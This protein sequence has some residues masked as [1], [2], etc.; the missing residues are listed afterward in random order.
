MSALS[1]SLSGKTVVIVGGASGI[2]FAVAQAARAEGAMVRIASSQA[3][4]VEAAVSR[5]GPGASGLVVD[6]TDEASVE[7]LFTALG[8]ID[9]L[10]YTAGDWAGGAGAPTRDL[11]LAAAEAGLRVRFWG[12]LRVVK[13]GCRTLSTHGSIT[14][15]DGMFAHR[16]RKGAP[17]M[18]A[19]L[20]ALEHLTPAL[21]VDLAP[22]R[23]N[24]VCPGLVMTE[25]TLEMP[26][27]MVKAF[28]SRLPLPRAA[29]PS[30]VAEA[31]LY[32]MKGG[33]TTGQVLKVDGG[34]AWV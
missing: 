9:H 34:G 22:I 29:E 32:L 28:T 23:V 5:M 33:Y 7:A 11:D 25:R 3:G 14:L 10:V 13:Y 8:P 15:T 24:A 19:V 27:A 20:G 21:A 16:P 18:T 31:Y 1:S 6:V 26:E 12:A 2:G 30:E 4:K 17:F